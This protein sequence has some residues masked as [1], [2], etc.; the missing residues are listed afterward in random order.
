MILTVKK[1]PVYQTF[2]W[3]GGKCNIKQ[4]NDAEKIKFVFLQINFIQRKEA[5][6]RNRKRFILK[7]KAEKT[8]KL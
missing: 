5:F 6:S 4:A 8:Y 1:R 3:L 2:I 7:L